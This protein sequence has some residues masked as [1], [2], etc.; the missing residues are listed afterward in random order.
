MKI[1]NG[2][3]FNSWVY[4]ITDWSD[5]DYTFWANALNTAMCITGVIAGLV[6]K[7]THGYKWPMT[8]GLVVRSTGTALSFAATYNPHP[9]LLV[10]S[11]ILVGIGA[12]FSTIGAMVG[13]QASVPHADL[14]IAAAVLSLIT[15]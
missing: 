14:A 10:M 13:V 2:I 5:R 4:V 1:A 11:P 7:Y 8:F 12:A 9:A 15:S 6:L 3:Y